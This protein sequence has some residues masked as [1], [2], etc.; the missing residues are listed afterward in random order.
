MIQKV[1]KYDLH[2]DGL[3]GDILRQPHGTT[4]AAVQYKNTHLSQMA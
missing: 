2:Y 4:P 1:I 3:W